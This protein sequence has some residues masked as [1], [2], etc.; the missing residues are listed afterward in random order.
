MPQINGLQFLKHMKL[1]IWKNCAGCLTPDNDWRASANCTSSDSFHCSVSDD[2]GTT[3]I[4]TWRIFFAFFFFFLQ[5]FTSPSPRN[6]WLRCA[7]GGKS[8]M[9]LALTFDIYHKL[10]NQEQEDKTQLKDWLACLWCMD[11]FRGNCSLVWIYKQSCG[12]RS[13][14]K[15]VLSLP[16]QGDLFLKTD[17]L[18]LMRQLLQEPFDGGSNIRGKKFWVL[19]L[20]PSH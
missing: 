10:W 3:A 14:S 5:V 19:F 13:R 8:K 4:Q 20:M 7:C 1:I 16:S 6:K 17:H 2:M 18:L 11:C 12:L 9:L 15:Q